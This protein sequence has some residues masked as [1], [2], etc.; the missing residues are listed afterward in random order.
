M[1]LTTGQFNDSYFPILDGVG[2]T[3]HN[4]AYWLNRK[5]GFGAVAAPK[6]KGYK[7][8]TDYP[9]YRFKSV[10]LPGMNPYR[11]GLPFID[12]KFKK[13]IRKVRFDLVHAHCPFV[14]GQFAAQIAARQG[15]P[16]VTTFH[17]KYRED[18]KKVVN[19]DLFADFLVKSTLE[20]YKK[21]DLV[22]VPNNATGQTLMEY[23]YEGAWEVMPNGTD[24]PALTPGNKTAIR[25]TGR[26][27]MGYG[28]GE[29][30]MLFVGQH[31]WEK[32][33]R[34]IIESLK[35]LKEQ[36]I[37]FRMLFAG[38]GYAVK[39]M[40]ALVIR[41]GLEEQVRFLGLIANRRELQQ[42]YAAADLLV[43]PSLYDNSPL[44]L[45]EAAACRVPSVVVNGS[46]SAEQV[47][48]GIN[49]F[50]TENETGALAT[51]LA[52]LAGKSEK[53]AKAGDGAR[54][55]LYHPWEGI[56]DEVY[57][58]YTELISRHK[59]PVRRQWEDDEL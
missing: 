55:S 5:Y 18:F 54:K 35:V 6:V 56:V 43:F 9:V 12:V 28:P 45:Q 8:H 48:D 50:I 38:E 58:K 39:E 20:F 51:L 49:G 16:L 21:A 32:N 53:I 37:P 41:Y 1:Q 3:A 31:R 29:F 7:D 19:N 24:F 47:R 4:Y 59:P 42:L 15:I 26:T 46:S 25:A 17:T 23:G 30:V 34:L 10:L 40:E 14:S 44:V 33:V 2:M 11:V 22:W 27:G 57:Q 36:S 52:D 13:R